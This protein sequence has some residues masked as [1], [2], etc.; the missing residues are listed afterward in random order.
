MNK[1]KVAL[2][3]LS[4]LL[5]VVALEAVIRWY[6]PHYGEE[7]RWV[8]QTHPER[9]LALVPNQTRQIHFRHGIRLLKT[10]EHGMRDLPTSRE[11]P[12]G[13]HRI[14]L[15]GDSF[16][17]GSRIPL[18]KTLAKTLERLLNSTTRDGTAYQVLNF[19]VDGYNTVQESLFYQEVGRTFD[20]DLVILMLYINDIEDIETPPT[21]KFAI[22]DGFRVNI[23]RPERPFI[24]RMMIRARI[25]LGKRSV[26]FRIVYRKLT[27]L[28]EVRRILVKLGLGKPVEPNGFK[29]YRIN[30]SPAVSRRWQIAQQE[31]ENMREMVEQ[32]GGKFLLVYIP[33]VEQVDE[34]VVKRGLI[35]DE[36]N[37]LDLQSPN[38]HLYN[39]SEDKNLNYLDLTVPFTQKYR[40]GQSLYFPKDIHWNNK[41]DR[42]AAEIIHKYIDSRMK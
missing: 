8:Y 15:F 5:T 31:I 18:E 26:L 10:N 11:K 27:S 29:Y 19:G 4:F 25:S 21:E 40:E 42:A 6:F 9:G 12:P 34:S 37:S 3:F 17:E 38:T 41:G 36:L 16:V 23:V 22:E 1:S 20:L 7:K 28:R 39:F 35:A 14:G 13:V 24:I 32:D 2:V 33:T 30:L